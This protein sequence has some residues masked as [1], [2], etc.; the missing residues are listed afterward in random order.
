MKHHFFCAGNKKKISWT[1]QN[2]E[3]IYDQTRDHAKIF[4]DKIS[5]EQSKYIALHVGIFWGI[6][7]FI[8]KNGDTIKILVDEK[9]MYEN[10]TGNNQSQD[11]LIRSRTSFIKQIIEQRNLQINFELIEQDQ[12]LANKKLSS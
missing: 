7:R 10:L 3:I 4:L 6:G 9:S 2:D 12:N 11:S 8:I 1:I 5:I